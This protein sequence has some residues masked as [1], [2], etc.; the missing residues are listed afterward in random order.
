[1]RLHDF[2]LTHRGEILIE[3][4]TFARTCAPASIT[5]D[6]EALRD[7][8]SEMLTVIAADLGTYQSDFEQSEKSK[9]LAPDTPETEVTAAEEHGAERARSGFTTE[10]TVA[11]YRALRASVLRLW[12]RECRGLNAAHIEDLTRFNEA[13]D[14]S[15][16]ESI[17][18]F[19]GMVENAK[20]MFLAILGHDL[21]NPLG[22]IFTSAMFL[23]DTGEMD[24]TL[25]LQIAER[26]KRATHMVGDLL[27]FTRSRLGGGIPIHPAEVDLREIVVDVVDEV[28]AAHP[29]GR[30]QLANGEGSIGRWDAARISQALSNLV[31][32]AVEHGAP[33]TT[34]TVELDGGEEEV[35]LMIHNHGDTI[36]AEKLD[37]IFNPLKLSTGLQNPSASRP[38]GNLGLGLY[39]AERIVQ[40][41]G[42]RIGVESSDARGTTFTVHLP[43]GE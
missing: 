4:E 41:H 11:E 22:A 25:T 10:Q 39:I 30:V 35:S 9:G 20:E 6:V 27:D 31:G 1:M 12:T 16:A 5:M 3:W 19:T 7:H 37:G 36:P 28:L 29:E 40:A 8:V 14:Q 42:G 2:I 18:E 34:V 38:T 32:N 15:L 13:I 17:A 33:G 21:R 26:A 23:S 24:R 43:R